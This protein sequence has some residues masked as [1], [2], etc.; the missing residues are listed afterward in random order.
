MI[1][2]VEPQHA[3]IAWLC[4]RIQLVPTPHIQCIGQWD[5][6]KEE[7]VGVVGYDNWNDQAVEIHVAGSHPHWINKEMLYRA[8]YYPFV[9]ADRKVLI[10][11]VSSEN[12]STLE[13][14]KKL[15][16]KEMCRIPNGASDGDMVVLAMQ[17]DECRWLKLAKR[18]F[19]K[20]A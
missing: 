4:E 16:F 17:R 1:Q 2:I 13:F 9:L 11:K 5:N 10:G 15:G 6:E 8:F 3:L 19:K 12:K 7:L 20:A 14:D 18:H